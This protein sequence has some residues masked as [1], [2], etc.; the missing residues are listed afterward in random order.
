M[1]DTL[2]AASKF[3]RKCSRPLDDPVLHAAS[4][5][6]SYPW[7]YRRMDS[8]SDVT[9]H[10]GDL[11]RTAKRYA[12]MIAKMLRVVW[13]PS[14]CGTRAGWMFAARLHQRG[15]NGDA[16]HFFDAEIQSQMV[17]KHAGLRAKISIVAVLKTVCRSQYVG[18]R[19]HVSRQQQSTTRS[20]LH[21]STRQGLMYRWLF[22][23]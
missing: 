4:G 12:E 2:D 14:A 21:L 5:C 18:P 17:L 11:E 22:L 6:A 3:D 7:G 10:R 23:V 15:A 19:D 8:V 20:P 9:K 16:K 1:E 13:K